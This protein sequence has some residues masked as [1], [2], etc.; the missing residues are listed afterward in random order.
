MVGFK[1]EALDEG[2]EKYVERDLEM[3]LFF[4]VVLGEERDLYE[5]VVNDDLIDD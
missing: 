2:G 3:S 1:N 5:C 4:E